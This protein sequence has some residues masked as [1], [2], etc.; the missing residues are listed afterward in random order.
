MSKLVFLAWW[1]GPVPALPTGAVLWGRG[2]GGIRPVPRDGIVL[3]CTSGISGATKCKSRER[4]R[5]SPC[6]SGLGLPKS[7]IFSFFFFF[8]RQIKLQCFSSQAKG[9]RAFGTWP[10]APCPQDTCVP[11]ARALPSCFSPKNLVP[12]MGTGSEVA[13]TS[14]SPLRV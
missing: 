8:F 6:F 5:A 10:P 3:D 9:C 7:S 11:A 13:N 2:A 12:R 1:R 4:D 14:V